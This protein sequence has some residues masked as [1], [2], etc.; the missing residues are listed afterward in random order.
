[1]DS[2]RALDVA[3]AALQAEP[4]GGALF[5]HT[6]EVVDF[7]A[8]GAADS[9]P[10]HVL[11]AGEPVVLTVEQDAGVGDVPDQQKWPATG[12]G[13]GL[14]GRVGIS[15]QTQSHMNCFLPGKDGRQ[16]GN[17]SSDSPISHVS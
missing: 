17:T 10:H 6:A 5:G 1:M 2:D 12:G 16:S 13:F 14:D 11:E 3:V 8:A 4:A 7:T 9:T 15:A